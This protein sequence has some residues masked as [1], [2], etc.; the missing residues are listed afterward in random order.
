SAF[1]TGEAGSLMFL[2]W[3]IVMLAL[4]LSEHH[5]HA[6]RFAR[7][8]QA[9][10]ILVGVVFLAITMVLSPFVGTLDAVD[11]LS[12]VPE[13]GVGLNPLLVN[14]W[15][16][17][18]PPGVFIPYGILVVVFASSFVHI[19][20]GKGNVDCN[21]K[22][23]DEWETFSRP[24]ARLAWILLGAGIVTGTMWSY[25][26]WESYWIWDPAFTSILMTWLLF[27]AYLH[28]ASMYQRGR[29]GMFTPFLAMNCFILSIYSTYIIRSGTVQSAHAFGESSQIVHLLVLVIALFVISNGLLIHRYFTR[30]SDVSIKECT[31]DNKESRV[32]SAQNMFY[33]TII[34]LVGLSFI[35]FWGLTS[36][37]L[38]N[39]VGAFISVDFYGAWAYPF[40][41]ALVAVLGI[42]MFKSPL[43]QRNGIILGIVLIF[44]FVLLKPAEEAASNISVAV[45]VFAGLGSIYQVSNSSY[46][47]GFKNKLRLVAPHIVHLGIVLMLVGV[48][49]STYASSETVL[50]MGMNEKKEVAGYEI[51]LTDLSFPLSHTHTS[52]VLTKIGTYGIYKN[53]RLLD[54]GEASFREIDDEFIT[55]PFI[56][57]GLFADVNVR[58]QG[59]GT[60]TPVF[61]SIANVRVI[62]GMTI[63][64]F[65]CILMVIG[66]IPLLI[67]STKNQL[68]AK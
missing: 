5:G 4:W 23:D 29:L 52:A 32:F 44:A 21:G 15:M 65:G 45:L 41:L 46:A 57:R 12:E 36:S 34:L 26:V 7:R 22:G 9:I 35:L 18:H 67:W 39:Y 38:F 6:D 62:P 14:I 56:Y 33:A 60:T 59:I 64:W 40:S 30:K 17:F 63:I 24:Y 42:C 48:L 49:L 1:W 47:S 20:D 37:L 51:Q 8:V 43:M 31:G 55:D 25:E 54:S 58:Y 2:S 28:A 13:D 3:V 66:I 27:T 53:G 10:V 19:L 11:G 16:V 50:F 61:V 68:I